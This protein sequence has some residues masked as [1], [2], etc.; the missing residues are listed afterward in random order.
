MPSGVQ[1]ARKALFQSLAQDEEPL[2]CKVHYFDGT[3][4]L[5]MTDNLKFWLNKKIEAVTNSYNERMKFLKEANDKFYLQIQKFKILTQDSHFSLDQLGPVSLIQ[6][7]LVV[8]N[9]PNVIWDA[10]EA[11]LPGFFAKT[12]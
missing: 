4:D 7:L 8:N 6:K 9:D 5:E 12:V 10:F 2:I 3:E 11:V 1:P